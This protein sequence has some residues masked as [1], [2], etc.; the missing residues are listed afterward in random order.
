MDT[1]AIKK[2]QRPSYLP[3]RVHSFEHCDQNYPVSIWFN[4]AMGLMLNG[5]RTFFRR[6]TRYRQ[7]RPHTRSRHVTLPCVILFLATVIF[8][9][10]AI[11]SR[12]IR[13]E[14]EE[15]AAEYSCHPDDVVYKHGQVVCAKRSAGEKYL[16]YQPPGGGWNNQ[17]I[18]F[19]NAVIFAKLLN[20]TLIVHPLAPHGEILRLKRRLGLQG[21]YEVYNR[22]SSTKL[23][24]LSQV[25]D[26]RHLSRLVPVK[27][28][29][30]SHT[31][32]REHVNGVLTRRNVCHNGLVGVWVDRLPSA[33][34]TKA[35]NLLKNAAP[36]LRD[37]P[38]YR[39]S[40]KSDLNTNFKKVVS[41]RPFW[42]ILDE[43]SEFEED[44][45]YFE[46]GSLFFRRMLFTNKKR[47]L[48]AHAWTIKYIRLAPNIWRGV[49]EALRTI[50]HPF[51]AVHVRR[52]DHPSRMRVTVEYWTKQLEEMKALEI[53][54]KLYVATDEI[55]REWFKPFQELGYN[56]I[57][58]DD[59]KEFLPSLFTADIDP[60]KAQDILGLHEQ[61]I[62]AH[63]H[64]FVGSFYSTFTMYIQR[65]RYQASWQGGFLDDPYMTVS[66]VNLNTTRG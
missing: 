24:P 44:L 21:G 8:L 47:A 11:T 17:R 61:L 37:I 22:I 51:N 56:L 4:D 58:A 52:A 29:K 46:E 19:E 12:Y 10:L 3:L 60:D 6:T 55:N 39:Q 66:W 5:I 59:L 49:L 34:D 64:Y 41:L 26:L 36:H 9:K 30:S 2:P 48:E 45:L 32:F 53:T 20:R 28:V 25:I 35:W 31:R 54:S 16:S 15:F 62:C 57:F 38:P 65:L 13:H 7:T 42:G 1:V 50:G 27:E 18:A 33:A 63:A 40:C 23:V 43:L 14:G